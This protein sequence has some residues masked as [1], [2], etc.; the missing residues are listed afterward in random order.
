M[1]FD[2]DLGRVVPSN[3]TLTVLDGWRVRPTTGLHG[4]LDIPM[5]TGTPIFA[6]ADGVATRVAPTDSSDAGIFVALT[7][8]SGLVSRYLHLSKALVTQGQRVTKG[9]QIGLSG[10]TGLS[11]GPH[12]HFDLAVPATLLPQIIAAVGTPT[13]GF[14]ND[15]GFGTPIPAEPWLPVDSYASS[16]ITNARAVGVPLF[17]DRPRGAPIAVA[18]P[19]TT[20][21]NVIIGTVAVGAFV[22]LSWLAL[23]VAKRAAVTLGRRRRMN[24]GDN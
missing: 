6:A 22:G 15:F 7:H 1:V 2:P 23:R 24:Y 14:P 4:A 8:P 18:A 17:K 9:Q 10:T 3:V 21:R 16:V 5:P 11:E 13:T 20:T 19:D 12:L